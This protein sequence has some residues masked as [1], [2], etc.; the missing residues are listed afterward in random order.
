MCGECTTVDQQSRRYG[1]VVTMFEGDDLDG[2]STSPNLLRILRI[3]FF[4]QSRVC[5]VRAYR[6][7]KFR[8]F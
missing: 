5:D 2:S 7:P 1:V 4:F 8:V 3:L 6:I